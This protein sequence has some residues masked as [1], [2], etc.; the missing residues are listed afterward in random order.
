MTTARRRLWLLAGGNG[1]GKST[2]YRTRLRS[3]D[4]A[5]INADLIERTLEPGSTEVPS[6]A[7]AKLARERFARWVTRG[8]SFCYETVFSHPSKL[9]M[10]VGA[11]EAGYHVTLVYIHLNDAALNRL[12]VRQRVESGGHPVPED[13]IVERIPRTLALMRD[14]VR[15]ADTVL[16]FDNSDRED[17]F[18]LVAAKEG[19]HFTLNADPLPAW[20][21]DMLFA[22]A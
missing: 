5:F 10:L 9:A 22:R 13:K 4:I 2:F 12:R 16:L 21:S 19:R 8:V 6:Y 11:Q 20:A 1:A 15:R 18:R 17:P 3:R 7:A 14:A